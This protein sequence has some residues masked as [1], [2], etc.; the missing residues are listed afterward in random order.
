MLISAV[1]CCRF[2]GGAV[3]FLAIPASSIDIEECRL[4]LY[5]E[6]V[7]AEFGAMVGVAAVVGV[8]P[9]LGA[10][11]ARRFA[12]EG[13]VVAMMARDLGTFTTLPIGM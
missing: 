10:A 12:S 3:T 11:V 7:V 13:Y 8:G 5:L 2:R 6:L 4:P 9:G 1:S